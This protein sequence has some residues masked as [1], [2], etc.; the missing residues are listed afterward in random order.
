LEISIDYFQSVVTEFLRPTRATFVNTECLLQ[1]DDVEV[2]L[3]G[4]HW[5]CDAV[6]AYFPSSTVY[7][8]EVTYSTALSSLFTRLAAWDLYWGPLCESIKRDCKI[9]AGWTVKPW[10]FIP[11]ERRAMLDKRLT[12]IRAA[13]HQGPRMPSPEVTSLEDVTPWKYP[14]WNRKVITKEGD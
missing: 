11:D 7:L 10:L 6:A 2:P 3:K 1:L 13:T 8:C 5:Y 14:S 12:L 4:R 9:P